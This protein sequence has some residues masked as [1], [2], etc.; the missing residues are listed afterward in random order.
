[1][2]DEQ[3][4]M[5]RAW[6]KVKQVVAENSEQFTPSSTPESKPEFASF[7]M[8]VSP[9]R[10]KA[11]GVEYLMVKVTHVTGGPGQPYPMYCEVGQR[12]F[13]LDKEDK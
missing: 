10:I 7:Y 11:A 8:A 4:D 3:P 2:P 9:D 13:R 5:S 6:S 1:M 12:T